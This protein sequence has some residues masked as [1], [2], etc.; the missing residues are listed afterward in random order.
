[1]IAEL[2]LRVGEPSAVD[3]TGRVL[4]KTNRLS[5]AVKKMLQVWRKTR[6]VDSGDRISLPSLGLTPAAQV[7]SRKI[8][9][10]LGS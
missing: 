5:V 4:G 9:R 3:H 6:R 8:F 2:G 10:T 7:G 1:M